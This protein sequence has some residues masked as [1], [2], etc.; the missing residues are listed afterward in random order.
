MVVVMFIAGCGSREGV[1]SFVVDGHTFEVPVRHLLP[2]SVIWFS[3]L[4][5][6]RGFN[7]SVDPDEDA[8]KKI[9][10]TVEPRNVTCRLDKVAA[11]PMLRLACSQSG[12]GLPDQARGDRLEKVHVD[13]DE[14]QWTYEVAREQSG[15]DR[16]PIAGCYMLDPKRQLG[17]CLSLGRYEGIVYSVSFSDTDIGHLSEIRRRVEAL[18]SAWE[19]R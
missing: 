10:I 14:T 1:R 12:V 6:S 5:R 15:N 8:G 18:L 9:L 2:N 4:G 16:Y 3:Q 11:S 19:R 13:G 17:S 7:F